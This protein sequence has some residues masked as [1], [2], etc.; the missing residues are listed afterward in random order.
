MENVLEHTTSLNRQKMRADFLLF[1]PLRRPHHTP[2]RR[3][4]TGD[5]AAQTHGNKEI[6]RRLVKFCH[7]LDPMPHASYLQPHERE[8][9]PS[10]HLVGAS[11]P[12]LA[13]RKYLLDFIFVDRRRTD[14]FKP[15]ITL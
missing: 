9:L 6:E 4:S 2:P 8:H 5:A 10:S 15:R 1:Q 3:V 14:V 7:K 12:R 13:P 11:K